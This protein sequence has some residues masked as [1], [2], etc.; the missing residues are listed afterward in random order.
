M[1]TLT[2]E[3]LDWLIKVESKL[4][5]MRKREAANSNS[6]SVMESLS[7]L[8]EKFENIRAW[9]KARFEG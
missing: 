6:W 3:D 9:L 8:I 7:E 1:E 5:R 4:I 2:E